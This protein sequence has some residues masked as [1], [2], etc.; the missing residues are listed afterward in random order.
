VVTAAPTQVGAASAPLLP[1]L[2]ASAPRAITGTVTTNP[3]ASASV[4]ALQTIA[5]TPAATTIEAAFAA[6]DDLTG[7]FSMT[8]PVV[9]P[10]WASFTPSVT[11]FGFSTDNV[12]AGLYTLQAESGGVTKSQAIDVKPATVPP[13]TFVFP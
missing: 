1:P 4:R 7:A 12:A 6:A 9:A 3:S 13:V 2:A 11:P 5:T 10:V 8:L